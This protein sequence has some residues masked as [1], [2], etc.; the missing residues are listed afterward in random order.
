MA[1]ALLAVAGISVTAEPATAE[2][3]AV[4]THKYGSHVRQSVDVY[5]NESATTKPA[6]ILV[7]GGYWYQQTDW[8]D[9]A[10]KFADDGFQVFAIEYRLNFEAAWPAQRDDVTAAVDWVRQNAA[11]FD[12]DPDKIV[13]LGSSAGGQMA[14]DA[15]TNGTNALG[16]KGV[17]ALSPVASPYRAWTDG[18]TSTEMKV[19]KVRDNASILARCYPDSTDTSTAMHDSCWG[20]WRSMV[21]KNWVN[22]GDAPMYLV[23]SEG[24]FVPATHSTDLEATAEAKGVPAGDIETRVLT[25]SAHG[26]ALLSESTV[27]S[28]VVAWLK[29]RL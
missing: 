19:R 21:S 2:P 8:S 7:H 28:D 29:N 13:M 3:Q 22:P 6:L 11:Q 15:A 14:T 9:W 24:D 25:G 10:Q 17:V 4:A 12:T 5:W 27:H 26:A 20:T 1:A 18:N 23:H 16:L